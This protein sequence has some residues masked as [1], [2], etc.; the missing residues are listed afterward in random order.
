MADAAARTRAQVAHVLAGA[1]V[2][3]VVFLVGLLVGLGLLW[4]A[5]VALVVG[6]A[7][8]L[9]VYFTADAMALRALGASPIDPGTHP[10]LE[11]LVEGLTVAH[12]FRQ[13]DLFLVDD[14]AP[15]AAVIGRTP[16]TSKLIVTSGLLERLERVELEG[17]LAHELKHIRDYSEMDFDALNE[18]VAWYMTTDDI[19]EYE[20]ETDEYALGLGC[21]LALRAYREW[22]YEHIDAEAVEQKRYDYY[23]PEEIDAWLQNQ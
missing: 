14:A 11:N 4:S 9:V 7:A 1:V 23:T 21:G 10:R 22:L 3:V 12:G 19:S 15:N 8:A 16:Q 17:V 18:F 2:A 5:L 20:R 6:A 13:P